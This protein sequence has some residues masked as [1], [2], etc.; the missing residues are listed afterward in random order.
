MAPS[1]A[2]GAHRVRH[3]F[4]Q[5]WLVDQEVLAQIVR[6]AELTPSDHVLEVGPG[7]GVLTQALL[8]SPVAGVTAV[9]LDRDLVSGLEDRFGVDPRFTLVSG[10]ILS[11]PLPPVGPPGPNKVVAN[12]PYNITGPLLERLLGRLD[13]PLN[14]PFSRLVLLVQREVGERLRAEAGSSA[15]SALSV[16]MQLLGTIQGVCP[17]P[18][19]C[20]QPPPRVH[21][22][23]ILIDP[24]PPDQRL[25]K[26]L[27]AAL[28]PLL[29]RAFTARRKMLRNSLAGLMP[30][31]VLA[32]LAAEA[33]VSLQARPQELSPQQWVAFATRLNHATPSA[34]HAP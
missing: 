21:S 32:G 6:A 11:V 10:D 29:R 5:H 34:P 22:E 16:R 4:G 7:R 2:F 13:R 19:R 18:P 26:E 8:D 1:S 20:F 25:P 33:G 24:L 30:E 23:V 14:P 17:V 3:R 27:A 12:I 28:E 9:E 15:F 31:P